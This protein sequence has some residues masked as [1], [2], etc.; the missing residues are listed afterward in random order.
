MG[1]P[2]DLKFVYVPDQMFKTLDGRI[3]G[4]MLGTPGG[5]A[6]EFLLAL[7]VYQDMQAGDYE[8]TQLE[9]TTML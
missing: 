9:I 2:A 6:G 1:Y 3:S 8:M 5:D 7:I 4:P